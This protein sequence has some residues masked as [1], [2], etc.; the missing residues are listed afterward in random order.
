[1]IFP[2]F[3]VI[4]GISLTLSFA[5]RLSRGA[6]RRDLLRH[7]VRRGVIIFSSASF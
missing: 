1:M 6:T 3:L 7:T 5:S 4:V 2:S